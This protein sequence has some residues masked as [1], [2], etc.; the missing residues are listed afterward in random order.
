MQFV[1]AIVT[2]FNQSSTVVMG[3]SGQTV[4][5]ANIS[6][7]H[8]ATFLLFTDQFVR[9]CVISLLQVWERPLKAHKL[10]MMETSSLYLCWL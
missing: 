1:F 5:L 8:S 3:E 6:L 7:D 4:V 9:N 10:D 2:V